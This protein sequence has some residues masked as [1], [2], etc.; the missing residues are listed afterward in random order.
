MVPVVSG[1][2]GP[3]WD[4]WGREMQKLAEVFASGFAGLKP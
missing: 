1:E 3:D 4:G 2:P